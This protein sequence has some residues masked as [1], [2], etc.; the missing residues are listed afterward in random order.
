MRGAGRPDYRPFSGPVH[1]RS[2]QSSTAV[3]LVTRHLGVATQ[4]VSQ[5]TAA[6]W[7]HPGA[8]ETYRLYR[9]AKST[10]SRTG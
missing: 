5:Q 4:T 1:W 7:N 2:I 9:G 3:D 8:A 10:R 6:G